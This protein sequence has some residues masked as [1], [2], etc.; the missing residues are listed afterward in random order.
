MLLTALNSCIIIIVAYTCQH[1]L[2]Q[3]REIFITILC[4]SLPSY[5]KMPENLLK[6]YE[7]NPN[8][9]EDRP[10]IFGTR[11]QD[12]IC[13][14]QPLLFWKSGNLPWRTVI[15]VHFSIRYCFEYKLH[16][17]I[18]YICQVFVRYGCNNSYFPV[19]CE[20]LIRRRDWAWDRSFWLA[21]VRLAPKTWELAGIL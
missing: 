6:I 14:A 13:L 8:V 21:C 11:S 10:I 7:D 3:R 19:R 16:V 15:Y 1:F 4:K 12:I 9:S 17:Y 2:M 5:P 18:L 20:K